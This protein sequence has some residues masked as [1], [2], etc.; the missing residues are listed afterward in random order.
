MLLSVVSSATGRL[1]GNSAAMTANSWFFWWPV[2]ASFAC[3]L[4]TTMSSL[5]SQDVIAANVSAFLYLTLKGSH[6][7]WLSRTADDQR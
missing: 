3:L 4:R 2:I 6:D 7:R 1:K 5:Q